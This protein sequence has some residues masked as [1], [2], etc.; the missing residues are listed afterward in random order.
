MRIEWRDMVAAGL[1][2]G[3]PVAWGVASGRPALGALAAIGALAAS[4]VSLGGVSL[5]GVA[6]G[7]VSPGGVTSG[8]VSPVRV[9]PG[10][11]SSGAS[12]SRVL[13]Q[14]AVVV[15]DTAVAGL[16]GVAVAGRGWLTVVGVVL[17]A[18]LL[19]VVGGISR[20]MAEHS[21]RFIVFMVI[22]TGAAKGVEPVA[23]AVLFA[24]GAAWGLLV[25]ALCVHV[26][27]P[28]RDTREEPAAARPAAPSAR[29]L[30]RRWWRTLG[31]APAWQYPVRLTACLAA[32]E[33]VGLLWPQPAASW[34]AV[35]VVIVVRRRMDGA[36]RRS[37][38]RAAGTAAGVAA[39]SAVL[40]W[41]PP[42][43]LFVLLVAVLAAVRPV[44]KERN[45]TLYATV[46][47]P[48]VL[49]LME[50]GARVPP[51]TIGYRL[52]DTAIGCVLALGLGYLPWVVRKERSVRAVV[53]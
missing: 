49:L 27:R 4:G 19:A 52:A 48:L 42:S 37:V 2:L 41:V 46:M 17:I 40:L 13:R 26:R 1:G 51:A 31:S 16:A 39:G 10:G 28:R 53:G 20:P 34:I 12:L 15:A 32:A 45:Y 38:E 7:E 21:T 11:A 5:G 29:A 18:G 25:T 22:S 24:G 8:G 35:T 50:G 36:A 6:S 47:T 14:G 30:L 23:A 43:W 3:G 44:L 33:V 9:P